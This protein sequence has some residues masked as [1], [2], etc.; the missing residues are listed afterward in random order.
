M[1]PQ[2][3]FQFKVGDYVTVTSE[4]KLRSLTKGKI[5]KVQASYY[6]GHIRKDQVI[7]VIRDDGKDSAFYAYHFGPAYVEE[8]V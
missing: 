7:R 1:Q 5:Y 2:S 8:D 4:V 3:Q 6:L